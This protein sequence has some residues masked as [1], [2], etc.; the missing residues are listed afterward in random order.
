MAAEKGEISNESIHIIKFIPS[1]TTAKN[2]DF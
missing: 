2:V 1:E